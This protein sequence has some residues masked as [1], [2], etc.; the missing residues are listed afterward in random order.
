MGGSLTFLRCGCG[1]LGVWSKL[2]VCRVTFEGMY[3]TCPVA[4]DNP[5]I[6]SFKYLYLLRKV[7]MPLKAAWFLRVT[8]SCG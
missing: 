1:R 7:G 6:M 5:K 2:I 3:R 8:P 4:S